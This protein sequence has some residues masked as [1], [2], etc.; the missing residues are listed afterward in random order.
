MKEVIYYTF[1]IKWRKSKSYFHREYGKGL[2]VIRVCWTQMVLLGFKQVFYKMMTLLLLTERKEEEKKRKKPSTSH[3]M[4]V[5]ISRVCGNCLLSTCTQNNR[6]FQ[7]ETGTCTNFN[8]N[9]RL[10][11]V[12]EES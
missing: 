1:I 2:K 3:C 7:L 11:W 5:I 8:W 10:F 12:Q 6:W 4:Y 9:K